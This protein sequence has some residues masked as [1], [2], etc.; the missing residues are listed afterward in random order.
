ME[1]ERRNLWDK[2]TKANQRALVLLESVG[3]RLCRQSR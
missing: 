3:V 1:E 2:T